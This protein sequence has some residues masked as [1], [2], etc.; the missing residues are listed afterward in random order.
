MT[1]QADIDLR[2][3]FLL[4]MPAMGDDR[5]ERSVIYILGHD[6]EGA[7]GFVVNRPTD[8]LTLGEIASNL[9][10]TVSETGLRNL[11]VYIGGPVQPESG[12]VLYTEN[13]ADTDNNDPSDVP[14]IAVTQGLDILVQAARARGPEHMLLVLGYAGW[15]PGQLENEIQDNAW[16]I[17]PA[18]TADIFSPDP[19][20]LYG[21]LIERMGIDFAMLS[22]SGGEA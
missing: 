11:P 5:F 16:L 9:P 20:G 19:D 3:R 13:P 2:G 12:F 7:M 22:Q 18:E 14:H 6:H 21:R 8:G 1:A 17:C 15:G 10:E 4:A